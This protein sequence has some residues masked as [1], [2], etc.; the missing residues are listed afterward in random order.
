M[1]LFSVIIPLYNKEDYIK[2]TLESVIN[3]TF[4]DFEVI[5]INDGSTDNSLKIVEDI[6]DSRVTLLNQ[7]NCG[8]SATR[9][10]G[11][12]ASKGNIIAP[13]DADDIWDKNFLETISALALKFPE[14]SLYGTD[15][16]EEHSSNIKLRPKKNITQSLENK[17]FIVEDFFKISSNQNIF[18]QSSFAFKRNVF[19]YVKYDE[20]IDFGEDIDFYIAS[21]LRFKFA[22]YFKPLST[23]KLNLPNQLTQRSKIKTRL[24]NLDKYEKFICN[25][26]SL[27]LYLNQNRYFYLMA[28]RIDKDQPRITYFNKRINNN[29]LSYKQKILINCPLPILKMLKVLK[30]LGLKYNIRITAF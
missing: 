27:K 16:F 8:L 18:C 5:V 25:F 23:I 3:Q 21:A 4:T 7:N 17:M 22:Y 12:I 28:A 13:L 2:E 9:N 6:K 19:T 26:P 11:I 24:A 29:M 15:Y 10:H 30:L 14:A 20:T 1:P